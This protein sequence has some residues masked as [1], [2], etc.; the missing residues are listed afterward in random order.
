M[1]SLNTIFWRLARW[2]SASFSCAAT[3]M[4]RFSFLS[5]WTWDLKSVHS[6]GMLMWRELRTNREG[7]NSF[8][9][10]TSLNSFSMWS[11]EPLNHSYRF[12]K[13]R[14][15]SS[16]PGHDLLLMKFFFSSAKTYASALSTL[17]FSSLSER[18]ALTT[19]G[20]SASLGEQKGRLTGT[21]S[22]FDTNPTTF[23]SCE[24]V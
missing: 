16:V 4:S 13:R 6:C 21:R 3:S 12:W 20:G 17:L 2:K 10:S 11:T 8:L 5:L 19:K 23:Q 7:P 15:R 1:D 9:D 24:P 14:K 18:G 22:S